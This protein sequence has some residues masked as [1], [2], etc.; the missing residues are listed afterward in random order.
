[1]KKLFIIIFLLIGIGVSNNVHAQTGGKKRERVKTKK[2]GNSILTQYKSHGHADDFARGSGRRGLFARLFKKTAPSWRYKSAGSK[3][4]HF[5][6]NQFLFARNRTKGKVENAQTLDK[7]NAERA[8]H[9][10]RGSRA[11][12]SR[13]YK[14]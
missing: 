2:R 6:A 11:F 13:K 14:R 7:Q 10:V 12:K 8:K 9:R 3:R 1:L 5:K 4:S